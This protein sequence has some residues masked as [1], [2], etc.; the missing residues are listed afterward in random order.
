M[1]LHQHFLLLLDIVVLPSA[2]WITYFI[3]LLTLQPRD[4]AQAISLRLV[5]KI[6]NKTR[7]CVHIVEEK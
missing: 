3:S 2:T 5:Q 7:V 6:R 4:L 1:T